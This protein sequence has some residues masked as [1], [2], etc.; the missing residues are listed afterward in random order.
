MNR[1]GRIVLAPGS[2][3]SAHGRIHKIIHRTDDGYLVVQDV[4]SQQHV[5]IGIDEANPPPRPQAGERKIPDLAVLPEKHL[6]EA[7]RRLA[8]IG[9]LLA[10]PSRTRADALAAAEAAGVG[11]TT[12]YRWLGDYEKNG[13]LFA[14]LPRERG[15]A[16][17]TRL[18]DNEIEALIAHAIKKVW[19]TPQRQKASHV[20]DEVKLLC[21]EA[22][23]PVPSGP[24]IRKRIAAIPAAE[25]FRQRGRADLAQNRHEPNVGKLPRARSPLNIVQIDHTQLDVMAVDD[26]TR[27]PLGR[28]WIT[29]AIDSFSRVITG[30]YITPDS[31]SAVSAGMCISNSILRKH[32]YLQELGIPGKW[33]A[34]G[35]PKVLLAD[36][37][38]E[39]RGEMLKRACISHNIKPLFRPVKQPRYGAHIE[40]LMGT[41]ANEMRKLPGTTFSSPALRKGYDSE[42]N[43]VL[44]I[45][46]IE[47]IIVEWIVN[48]YNQSINK[49][50]DEAP[51]ALWRA[52]LR[53]TPENPG[54]GAPEIPQDPRRLVLDFMPFEER[55]I[56]P[57]GVVIDGIHYYDPAMAK[58]INAVDPQDYNKK[59]Q[60]IFRRDYRNISC[61]Y[62][63]EPEAKEYIRVPCRDLRFPVTNVWE[64][65]AAMKGL[66]TTQ[67]GKVD[68]ES[69]RQAV[70]RNQ[71]LVTTATAET[72]KT[73]KDQLRLDRA[74]M[75]AKKAT[76]ASGL[77]APV[78]LPT[79]VLAPTEVFNVSEIE[80]IGFEE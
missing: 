19:M 26:K 10:N 75:L 25:A 76:P 45:R 35:F 42:A 2:T 32:E 33:D 80:D 24:T 14:L 7:Q 31:P 11:V 15:R 18:I 43:A 39:F 44:T 58:W 29:L 12:I 3:I 59:R 77:P 54:A 27:Q 51:L 52:G 64:L 69:I 17:G 79:P 71:A 62:F 48:I 65:R 23:L 70:L 1:A 46:E 8:A 47:T 66:K 16:P 57:Y 6:D 38:R 74:H 67:R 68:E 37:A 40:R 73:R 56:Q 61:V 78:L 55:T 41:I 22:K 50:T 36:N 20:I 34:F 60:F 30:V 72:K 49:G 28:P 21:Q 13:E 63:W 9:P 53:G 5:T 4:E